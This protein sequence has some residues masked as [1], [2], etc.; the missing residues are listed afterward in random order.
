[1]AEVFAY[2]TPVSDPVAL[3]AAASEDAAE[4]PAA[5]SASRA[6]L[7][8]LRKALVGL[9]GE[10]AI[11]MFTDGKV[12]TVRGPKR[13]L[14]IALSYDEE[15][16]CTGAP[17]M[18]DQRRGIPR[19]PI[20]NGNGSGRSRSWESLPPNKAPMKPTANDT[21]QPPRDP[22]P[23]ARAMLPQIKATNKNRRSSLRVILHR[24]HEEMEPR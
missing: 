11:L 17:P 13:P 23:R 18:I 16:G 20:A 10:T 4:C 3:A 1:M 19:P 5:S 22:P 2:R 9:S 6:G 8:G 21:R 7:S 14:Q 12:S 15:V 24:S